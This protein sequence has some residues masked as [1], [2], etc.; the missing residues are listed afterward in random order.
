MFQKHPP[1]V[2]KKLRNSAR[3]QPCLVRLPGICK[4]RT[5]TTVL[6]HLNGGGMGAKKSDIFG[7]FACHECHSEIDRIT[8]KMDASYVELAHRQGVER[9]QQYWLENGYISVK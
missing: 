2:S 3:G 6:A 7:A 5:D 1:L 8:R 4:S 9:T